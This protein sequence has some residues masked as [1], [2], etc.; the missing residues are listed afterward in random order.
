MRNHLPIQLAQ[1]TGST[2]A[3]L[4]VVLMSKIYPQGT[5]TPPLTEA[6]KEPLECVPN[7]WQLHQTGTRLPV[8]LLSS[9]QTARGALTLG[10]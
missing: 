10:R 7:P 4:G 1:L 3:F 9:G 6:K 5:E 2:L 8:C